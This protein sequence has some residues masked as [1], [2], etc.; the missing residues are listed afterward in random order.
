[1]TFE[2]AA[3]DLLFRDADLRWTATVR[4]H[5]ARELECLGAARF[6]ASLVTTELY[7]NAVLHGA[8]PI[9]IRAVP[10]EGGVQMRVQDGSRRFGPR[11]PHSMG[12]RVVDRVARS[13]GVTHSRTGKTVWAEI[14]SQP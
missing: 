13:W 8:A 1:M 4:R 2:R 11:R 5:I 10:F 6:D 12:L 7:V 14:L 3:L 9:R